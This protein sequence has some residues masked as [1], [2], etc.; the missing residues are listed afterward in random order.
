MNYL[1]VTQSLIENRTPN[2]ERG[3]CDAVTAVTNVT[4]A[5]GGA[6]GVIEYQERQ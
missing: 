5:K 3:A 6:E 2:Q 1:S 4:N